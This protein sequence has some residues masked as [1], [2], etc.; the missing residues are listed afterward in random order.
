MQIRRFRFGK[1]FLAFLPKNLLGLICICLYVINSLSPDIATQKYV[2]IVMWVSISAC[3]VWD[4][5]KGGYG[6]FGMYRSSNDL[7]VLIAIECLWLISALLYLRFGGYV[8]IA[9][10]ILYPVYILLQI[11]IFKLGNKNE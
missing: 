11:I 4:Q 7:Y 2:R 8:G 1:R 6:D 5:I 9:M 3:V 10:I